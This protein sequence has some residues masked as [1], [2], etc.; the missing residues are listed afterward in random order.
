V[1]LLF[2]LLLFVLLLFVLL[3]VLLLFVLLIFVRSLEL[4]S[5][6]VLEDAVLAVFFSVLAPIVQSSS[7]ASHPSLEIYF[8]YSYAYEMLSS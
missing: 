7:Q 1:L 3:F 5:P 6:V 2:V 4:V 8:W